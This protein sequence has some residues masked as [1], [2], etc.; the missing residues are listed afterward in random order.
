MVTRIIR[1]FP[2]RTSFTPVDELAFVGDPPLERP[3]ADEVHVSC[4]FTWDRPRAEYLKLACS[5]AHRGNFR[6]DQRVTFYYP[7][8][9]R[10][11][12]L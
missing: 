4:T 11:S 5:Y 3:A 6:E 9:F 1:V 2:R 12:V 10:T 7:P 8:P